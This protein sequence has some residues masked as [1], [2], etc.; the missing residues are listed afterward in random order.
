MKYTERSLNI[1]VIRVPE[2]QERNCHRNNFEEIVANNFPKL[3]RTTTR[4]FKDR[5]FSSF[6]SE[7]VFIAVIQK[8]LSAS[9]VLPHRVPYSWASGGPRW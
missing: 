8:Q 6:A 3:R 7:F 2:R 1:Y 4:R 9:C 5:S